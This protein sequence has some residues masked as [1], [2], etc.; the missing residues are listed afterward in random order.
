MELT[1]TY[2]AA[3]SFGGLSQQS[4][5]TISTMAGTRRSARQSTS[6]APN[7]ADNS[8]TP[9]E[10]DAPKRNRKKATRQK[11]ARDTDADEVK[12]EE[13]V[14]MHKKESYLRI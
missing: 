12:D 13:Y 14:E 6:A 9:S 8:P 10:D 2:L 4:N 11:R 7:Y 3:S 5:Q 1:N